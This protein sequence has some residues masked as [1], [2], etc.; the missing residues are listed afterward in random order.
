MR[1]YFNIIDF[2]LRVEKNMKKQEQIM[3]DYEY[4]I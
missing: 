2:F 3:K 1:K 4:V